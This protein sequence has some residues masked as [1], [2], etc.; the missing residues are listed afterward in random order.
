MINKQ[1]MVCVGVVVHQ[2]GWGGGCLALISS[3]AT[4]DVSHAHETN[5][6]HRIYNTNTPHRVPASKHAHAHIRAPKQI[7]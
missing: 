7:T 4:L 1:V 2:D 3:V 6:K 5:R